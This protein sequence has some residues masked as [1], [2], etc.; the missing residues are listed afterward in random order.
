M[1]RRAMARAPAPR[2]A[3]FAERLRRALRFVFIESPLS[4]IV[5]KRRRLLVCARRQNA[6]IAILEARGAKPIM[7]I[8]HARR[9]PR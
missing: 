8:F 3:M 9:P 6:P 7:F 2:E 1:A 4:L 5:P